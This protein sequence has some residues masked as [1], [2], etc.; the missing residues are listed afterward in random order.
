MKL[1]LCLLTSY[2][3]PR[4]KRLVYNVQY[5]ILDNKF[6]DFTPII[7]VNTLFDD[8]YQAVLR[9]QFTV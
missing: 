9:E 6:F 3:L 7:V 4:L 2:D 1:M 5:E 8:Y